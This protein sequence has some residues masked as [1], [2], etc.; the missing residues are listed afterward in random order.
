MDYAK[1]NNLHVM[2]NGGVINIRDARDFVNVI[3]QSKH[4]NKIIVELEMS[5]PFRYLHLEDKEN[6]ITNAI[7][8]IGSFLIH[9]EKL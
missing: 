3:F 6:F 4:L 7:R 1:T 2:W 9:E 5:S 8:A